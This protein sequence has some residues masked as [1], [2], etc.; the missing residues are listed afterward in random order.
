MPIFSKKQKHQ[1]AWHDIY[2]NDISE[3]EK[4]HLDIVQLLY[5]AREGSTIA[6]HLNSHGGSVAAGVQLIDAIRCCEARVITHLDPLAYSMAALV[7]LCGHDLTFSSH[8]LLMFHNYSSG[9]YGKGNEQL[10]E[11][12]CVSEWYAGLLKEVTKGFLTA[13]EIR[14]VLQ[15]QDIWLDTKEIEARL[16]KFVESKNKKR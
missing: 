14:A 6:L 1:I 5:G 16:P 10:S 12:L 13:G 4:D 8:S 2:I 3:D 7:F 11:L 9:V 15:G